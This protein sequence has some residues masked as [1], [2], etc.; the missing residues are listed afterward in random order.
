MCEGVRR[1]VPPLARL[2]ASAKSPYSRRRISPQK[3]VPGAGSIPVWTHSWRMTSRQYAAASPGATAD[4]DHIRMLA[5]RGLRPVRTDSAVAY[6]WSLP[7][8]PSAIGQ[9]S[10]LA[11]PPQ[12]TGLVRSATPPGGAG[13]GPTR[14]PVVQ[15]GRCPPGIPAWSSPAGPLRQAVEAALRWSA[16]TLVG[17][18][19]LTRCR[20]RRP[21]HERGDYEGMRA[22]PARNAA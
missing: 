5:S 6:I 8:G 7:P 17:S 11:V 2:T 21:P 14:G 20:E 3:A 4:V 9:R 15:T 12:A 16:L 13:A 19:S 18:S 1:H 22:P 10:G